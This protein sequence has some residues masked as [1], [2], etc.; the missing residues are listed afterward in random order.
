[1]WRDGLR[2]RWVDESDTCPHWQRRPPD[3][4]YRAD[5]RTAGAITSVDARMRSHPRK[6][7]QEIP[8]RQPSGITAQLL[9][10]RR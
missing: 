6:A 1:M 7:D 5:G 9:V 10:E 8:T 2:Y 3:H 4:G